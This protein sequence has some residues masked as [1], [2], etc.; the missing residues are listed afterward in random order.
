MEFILGCSV[1]D[2]MSRENIYCAGR[3][4]QY[5][6]RHYISIN[7]LL[8]ALRISNKTCHVSIVESNFHVSVLS[9]WIQQVL[10]IITSSRYIIKLPYIFA[11]SI[12]DVLNLYFFFLLNFLYSYFHYYYKFKIFYDILNYKKKDLL[13]N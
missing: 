7:V 10:L 1:Y 6:N 11:I 4:Y 13:K 12:F 8:S 3:T 9:N 5:E 2:V